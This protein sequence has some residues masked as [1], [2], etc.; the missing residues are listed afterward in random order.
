MAGWYGRDA[1]TILLAIAPSPFFVR[2]S[3][4]Y[5]I[6][7]TTLK[8]AVR[9]NGP[10]LVT[11]HLLEPHAYGEDFTES[12]NEVLDRLGVKRYSLIGAMYDMVPHTRPLL[13]SGGTVDPSNEEEYRMVEVRPSDYEG[14]TTIT[15]LT[16]EHA[17]S[18]HMDTRIFVVHLPQYFQ[19]EEDFSGIARLT[20][21][22]CRIYGLPSRLE[23]RERGIQ[24]YESLQN[25][26][27]D[28][29]EVS[30]LLG[31]LEERYDRENRQASSGDVAMPPLSPQIEEFLQGLDF[32]GTDDSPP[33]PDDD[34]SDE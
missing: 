6:P 17:E 10:D 8:V 29:S 2:G 33:D 19:V 22:L 23:D 31:R 5:T 9:E 11:L 4:E 3:G 34:P 16:F 24:Q 27:T 28:T 32:G 20:G 21:I 26:V 18:V 25:I 13:V 7:T 30:K 15:H 12:V 1:T 14:P